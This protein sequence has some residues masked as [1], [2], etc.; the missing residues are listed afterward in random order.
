MR[1][2]LQSAIYE[3]LTVTD[4]INRRLNII[5]CRIVRSN[6]T[7]NWRKLVLNLRYFLNKIDKRYVIS[8]RSEEKYDI[9]W[10]KSICQGT[11]RRMSI[12]NFMTDFS[13]RILT[14]CFSLL[15]YLVDLG[16]GWSMIWYYMMILSALR[17][18]SSYLIVREHLV[19]TWNT[20]FVWKDMKRGH[21]IHWKNS[22]VTLCTVISR[23]SCGK[24]TQIHLSINRF[25]IW[26]TERVSE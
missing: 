1:R 21:K 12:E 7:R 13:S 25:S 5:G 4:Q 10:G 11:M 16:N 19:M 22:R 15:L 3:S 14:I 23:S 17:W 8:Y 18:I 6:S 9:Q 2:T 26:S 20:I 24:K